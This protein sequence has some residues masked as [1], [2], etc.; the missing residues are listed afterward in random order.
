M[1]AMAYWKYP[2]LA[3]L[4]GL[5]GCGSDS[6]TPA[7]PPFSDAAVV[8]LDGSTGDPPW[9][10]GGWSDVS[11]R[12]P[13]AGPGTTDAPAS[14]AGT[15]DGGTGDGAITDGDSDAPAPGDGGS[16]AASD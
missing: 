6:G 10:D 13:D 5:A 11:V 12:T 7:P 1:T 15:P 16:D 14:E 4:L 9:P 2:A 3:A 8:H